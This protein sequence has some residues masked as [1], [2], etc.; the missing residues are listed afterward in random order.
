LKAKGGAA[1]IATASS[2]EMAAG[3][4]GSDCASAAVAP[5]LNVSRPMNKARIRICATLNSA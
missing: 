1:F 3:G 4:A 5:A 2:F